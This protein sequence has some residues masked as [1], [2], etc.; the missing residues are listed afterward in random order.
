[1]AHLG[2]P[3]MTPRLGPWLLGDSLGMAA[4]LAWLDRSLD[5]GVYE[6]TVECPHM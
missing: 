5:K 6:D 1:M 4:M 3:G 2:M